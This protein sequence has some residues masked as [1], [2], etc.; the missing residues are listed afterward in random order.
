MESVTVDSSDSKLDAEFD[1]SLADMKPYVLKLPHKT[2]R[3]RCA[4]WIKKLCEPVAPGPTTRKNRNMYAELLLHM[5]KRGVLEG[6]FNHRPGP[7][8]LKTLPSYMSIYFDDVP[9]STIPKSKVTEQ[10]PGIPDWVAGELD[11]TLASSFVS[12]SMEEPGT[13]S[14]SRHQPHRR[15]QN[16]ADSRASRVLYSSRR[17]PSFLLSS[18]DSEE[19]TRRPHPK[20]P[21]APVRTTPVKPR[22]TM[23]RSS[24][25]TGYG[26]SS[27]RD[28]EE[29]TLGRLHEKELEMRTKLLESRFHEEMLVLQQKHD[30]AVQKILDRKNEEMEDV[31]QHYRGKQ[32]E[33]E[34][35]V[36]KLEKKCQ[37]L[38]KES[39]VIRENRDR[40]IVELKKMTEQT[41]ASTQNEY[42][43]RLHDMVAD[44]EQ[45][46][47]DM[48]KQH[49]K[50]IQELLDDTN[51]RLQKMEQEYQAQAAS[52]GSVVRELEARVAQLTKDVESSVAERN[53][54]STEKLQLEHRCSEISGELSDW[55]AKFDA[56]ERNSERLK[57]DHE[58]ELRT[59]RNKSEASVEYLKQENTLAAAKAHDHIGD[60][61]AHVSQLKQS[62]QESEHERQRQ[63]RE[64]EAVHQQDKMHKENLHEKKVRAL[65]SELE[66]EKADALKK[67]RK[68]EESFKD[69]DEQIQKMAEIQKFQTQQADKALEDFKRQVERNSNQVYADMKS[70]MEKVEADLERSKILREKQQ[71]EFQRQLEEERQRKEH[72][73]LEVKVALEQ[74]KQQMLRNHQNEK[75]VL[76]HEHE[77]A[78]ESLVDR[79]RAN[80]GEVNRQAEERKDRDLKT[81][82]EMEQQIR[83]LREEVIQANAL[84]KQQLVELGLLREEEKQKAT[85]STQELEATVNKFKSEL[86]Q[87]KLQLQRE[88][89]T[90]MEQSLEMTNS[91]LKQIEKEYTQRL[92]KQ[93][94]TISEL[95]DTIQQIREDSGR[96]LTD[97][98]RRLQDSQTRQGE[99]VQTLKRQHSAALRSLQQDVDTHKG[100][101]RS[102]EKRL[103]QQEIDQQEKLTHLQQ[104]YEDRMRGL[105]P[106]SLRQELEDTIASLKAQVNSVQ[107]RAIILQEELDAK[108][109]R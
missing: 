82:S 74:E 47:F 63:M 67:I 20:S 80:M 22:T 75:D 60:L 34:E 77:K 50:N 70:Q 29:S 32:Q 14:N 54:L 9:K 68:L 44:F 8:P 62:L 38:V 57:E 88:H 51:N 105:M 79:L 78:V 69:K 17:K 30:G 86:E 89:A 85:R 7:G 23:T 61:E 2:E 31:K 91:R 97:A 43:K 24:T 45:E 36:K 103:Q 108:S 16:G 65:H 109:R 48:Q 26:S 87:Q 35:Q 27:I 55:Q 46:K 64:L 15:E 66:Q 101:A 84:R 28:H 18:D 52:T 71:R 21:L 94:E 11:D 83:E 106:A 1:R 3:Q 40:Q 5:L 92:T 12:R 33:L 41:T 107:Q 13:L 49:T 76:Q 42:E 37:S 56:L 90:E 10:N 4:L 99:E 73:M 58:Q 72:K 25:S 6:P 39:Q 102:L 81:I 95:Q 19:E 98:D 96:Q 100:Q 59:L 93:S 53:R 104:Q